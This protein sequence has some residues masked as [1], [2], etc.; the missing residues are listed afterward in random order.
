MKSLLRG[1]AFMLLFL[2][3]SCKVP[4]DQKTEDDSILDLYKSV[5]IPRWLLGLPGPDGKGYRRPPFSALEPRSPGGDNRPF[6]ADSP[7][8]RRSTLTEKIDQTLQELGEILSKEEDKI[9]R[10]EG[11]K[12]RLF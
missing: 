4:T 3:M 6:F 7:T 9:K 11:W 10:V 1:G 5:Q 12:Q 8:S 2:K